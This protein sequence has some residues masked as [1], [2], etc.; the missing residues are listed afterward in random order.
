MYT[1]TVFVVGV[2]LGMFALR[3]MQKNSA[4]EGLSYAI[5]VLLGVASCLLIM[6][7]AVM[8]FML[9]FG[10]GSIAPFVYTVF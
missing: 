4:M 3:F 10:G 5:P 6:V 2:V 9:L 8:L 1:L 7:S